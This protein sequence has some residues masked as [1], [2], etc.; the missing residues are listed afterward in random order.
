[1]HKVPT[2]MSYCNIRI[3]IIIEIS[4]YNI[5]WHGRGHCLYT[6]ANECSIIKS[7][8][9]TNIVCILIS[10]YYINPTITSKVRRLDSLN[11]RLQKAEVYLSHVLISE[12]CFYQLYLNKQ[13]KSLCFRRDIRKKYSTLV[14]TSNA[15]L[16]SHTLF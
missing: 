13:D 9:D 3:R 4:C 8:E 10:N 1:M 7:E 15:Y 14:Y 6:I 11:P 12:K 2:P 5:I 16:F